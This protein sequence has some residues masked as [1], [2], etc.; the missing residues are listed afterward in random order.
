MWRYYNPNP[1][2]QQT[3]DCAV[4]AICAATEKPWDEVYLNLCLAGMLHGDWGSNNAVWGSYLKSLGYKREVIP[5]TCPDCYAVEKFCE[6]H[7]YGTFI[8]AVSGHVVTVKDG[9]YYDSWD[10]GKCVPLYYWHKE[11]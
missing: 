3:G 10:S 7:P 11:D 9:A 4:R 5:N 1:H 2:G 8:L 6:D